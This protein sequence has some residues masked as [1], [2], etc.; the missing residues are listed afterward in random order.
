MSSA[1]PNEPNGFVARTDWSCSNALDAS[2]FNV[3][4]TQN[5]ASDA[6]APLSPP[7]V[8]D[9]YL[10]VG[11]LYG[12]GQ[13]GGILNPRPR[14][15]F[16][17]F[18]WKTNAA[19]QG[20][21]NNNNKLFFI[22]APSSGDN[23]F[24]VFQGGQDAP[25]TCKW[26]QQAQVNNTHVPGVFN[27]NWPVDGTGWFDPNIN[28]AAATFA[29]SATWRKVEI[30][31]KSSTTATSRD[32]W[33]RLWFNGTLSTSH[34]NVNLM[35]NG[36]DEWQINHA[37]D[38]S[39]FRTDLTRE[40]HHYFDHVYVSAPSTTGGGSTPVLVSLTPS[41]VSLAPGNTQSMTV[42]MSSNVLTNTNIALSSSSTTVATVPSSVTV[43]NGQASA[44]FTCTAVG[45]GSSTLT[46][47]LSGASFTSAVTVT[48]GGGGGGGGTGTTTT[49]SH[50]SQFSTTQNVN[51]WSYRDGAG[52]LLSYNA[53]TGLWENPTYTYLGI[54]NNG[55]HPGYTQTAV[56]RWTAS[57]TGSAR[58]T[59]S[60]QDLD[61]TAGTGVLFTI[62]YGA[63]STI[64][65]KDLDGT[66][67]AA[68]AYDVTQ[69]MS[70]GDFI[71]F[72]VDSKGSGAYDSTLLNPVIA[73]TTGSTSSNPGA[74]TIS[75][76]TPTSGVLGSSVT[77]VG[78]NFNSTLANNTVTFNG[79]QATVT[80]AS[81]TQ[82]VVTV[83][84]LATTGNIAV[85]T[86]NG[87]ATGSTFTVTDPVTPVTPPA[88]NFGGNAMLLLVLP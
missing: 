65:S 23:S 34:S 79:V 84:A 42:G 75:S 5:Y 74:P 81:T 82:L 87:T 30:H 7:L 49:Y 3:Y 25:K 22:R 46:A 77:I 29:M 63:S 44:T 71:D 2:M 36:I 10:G 35:Y 55:C 32:G 39:A 28:S 31:L 62:K 19:F 11:T 27:T 52:N 54:W 69:A 18:W 73:F 20:T 26:Y 13:W 33:I 8:F 15:I 51:G 85:T 78:T 83:P 67:A 24:M 72:I 50:S 58:I 21:S 53:V 9:S 1:F 80:S 56:L 40:W 48:G 38:G 68:Y 45:A 76:F 14:E 70:S 60:V 16:V 17:G 86:S 66:D 4:N 64:Y 41:S 12:N 47:A 6:T 88:T 59:G 43:N 37:W 57:A 61:T